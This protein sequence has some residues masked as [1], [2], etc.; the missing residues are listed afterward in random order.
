MTFDELRKWGKTIG[1]RISLRPMGREMREMRR[2]HAIAA[3]VEEAAPGLRSLSDTSLRGK[4]ADLRNDGRI[5]DV[6]AQ[7]E[8]HGGK[9][10]QPIHSIGPHGFRAIVIDSEGNRIALHSRNDA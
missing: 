5:Q 2:L 8:K 10:V 6:V 4:A 3:R 9:I 7:T 1:Q